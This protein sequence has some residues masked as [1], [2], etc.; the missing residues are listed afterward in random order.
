MDLVCGSSGVM[1]ITSP[2][3]VWIRAL[4]HYLCRN[5]VSSPEIVCRLWPLEG[6]LALHP[7]FILWGTNALYHASLLCS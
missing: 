4:L 6:S 5:S 7:P 2:W 3:L 1:P